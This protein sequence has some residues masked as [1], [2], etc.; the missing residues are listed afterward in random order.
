MIRLHPLAAATMF[1]LAAQTASA[2]LSHFGNF[3]PIPASVASGSLP[4]ATPF[5][6]GSPNFSQKTVADRA[7]QL[8]NGQFNSG[9]WDMIDTNRSGTDAGRY[10]FSVFET[11]Q[12]GVQ[13]LDRQ[14]GT[15]V[16]LWNAP[17][18]GSAVAFDASRWTPFGTY[19]TA[20][21]SWGSQP[22]PYGRLFELTNPTSAGAGT[23]TLVHRNAIARVSHE[24]LAFDKNNNLYYID[25]LNGGSL[26]RYSSATPTN[27]ATYFNGGVNAVMRIGDGNTANATGAASWISFTDAAGVGLADAVTIIDPNGINSVDGR[28]TTNVAKYKGTDYQRPEDLEI[29]NLANG[30]Q[31]LYMATTTTNEVYSLNLATLQM[32][33]FVNRSTIDEATGLA[34]GNALTSPDNLAIDA[35]GNI[36]IIED[37]PGGSADIW[38]A[39]DADRNGV[40]ESIGRWATMST[41]GAE[42]TGLY[43]DI[44]N[45]NIAF[46]NVQHPTSGVDRMIQITAVPEPGTY[47]MMLGGLALLG[48]I[49][50]RRHRQA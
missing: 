16:T 46:V 42:P 27:G 30:D 38:F 8:A 48:G 10:L 17:A 45:P 18:P 2:Q 29:Q 47:A 41:A 15:T 43:F 40:A 26:Y 25:E 32:Q 36:Y 33:V 6:L 23:G 37:Q 7:T 14:T 21:E 5:Q 34:V 31:V 13:R 49:A 20:E 19:L 4:E 22:Q 3:T 12:A 35:D 50:R 11:S 24:G 28:A 1:A 9:S 44:T 39:R